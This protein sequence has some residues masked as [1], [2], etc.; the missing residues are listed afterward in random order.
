MKNCRNSRY[1]LKYVSGVTINRT[2]PQRTA[3]SPYR[4]GNDYFAS[5][6]N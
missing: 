1:R 2:G 4:A 6:T 5:T 3:P